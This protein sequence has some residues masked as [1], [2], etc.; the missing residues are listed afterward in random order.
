M[1][2]A[3]N[4]RLFYCGGGQ[5]HDLKNR[6]LPATSNSPDLVGVPALTAPF[7]YVRIK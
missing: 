7:N 1:L 2:S 6:S 5:H 4:G 3:A